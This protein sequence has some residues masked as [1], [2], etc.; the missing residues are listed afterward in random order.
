MIEVIELA[1][2][3]SLQSSRRPRVRLGQIVMIPNKMHRHSHA[4]G[5][6]KIISHQQY[7]KHYEHLLSQEQQCLIFIVCIQSAQFRL[8]YIV[9]ISISEEICDETVGGKT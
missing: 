8:C 5:A 4:A 1:E 9:I 3:A 6:P 2:S 7:A